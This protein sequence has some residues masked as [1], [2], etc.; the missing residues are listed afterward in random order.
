[1]VDNLEEG[2]TYLTAFNRLYE[3]GEFNG[4]LKV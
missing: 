3:K 2:E 4:Q 1:M